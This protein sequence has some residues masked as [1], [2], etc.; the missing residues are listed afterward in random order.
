MSNQRGYF[1]IGIYHPKFEENVGGLWRSAH[2]LGAAFIFTIGARYKHQPTDTTKAQRHIPLFEFNTLAYFISSKPRDC[3]LVGIEIEFRSVPLG[4][5]CHQERAIYILGA[6][7]TG[8]AD[9][10][11]LCDNIIEVPS[12]YCLNVATTGAIVM[13]D[14]SLGRDHG[15]R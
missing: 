1:G 8:L 15:I 4:R 7:D 14:R 11:E 10:S 5:F 3:A 9:A 2:A 13:Y 12:T 6:E